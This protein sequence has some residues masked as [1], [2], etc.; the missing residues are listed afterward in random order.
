MPSPLTFSRAVAHTL[1][2]A[3]VACVLLQPSGAAAQP[4]ATHPRLWLTAADLPRLRAWA[5]DSNP[6]YR[7][8]LLRLATR[9]KASMDAGDVPGRDADNGGNTY[10]DEPAEMYAELF[11]FMSLVSPVEADRADYARRARTLLMYVVERALPGAAEGEPY[12]D[13]EFSVNDRSRWHGEAFALTADWI[14][15]SLSPSDRA[16]LRT[17]FLRWI[18]E[19]KNAAITAHDHPEPIGVVNDPRLVDDPAKLRWALNNY[20]TAHMRNIGLMS[21]ALDPA[22]DPDGSLRG[23]LGNATGAWLYVF[24][25]AA[26]TV[27]QGGL[28]PEG[29]E[30][31]PQTFGYAAQLLL[32]LK[33]AGQD[34]APANGP[35][36][37]VAGNPF[38]DEVVNGMLHSLSPAPATSAEG[39]SVHLPAWFGDGQH[40]LAPDMIALF[41]AL[42]VLDAAL[43]NT[44]R[45]DASRFLQRDLAPG[46]AP[47][48]ARR[49]YETE[50]Y[51][52]NAV[53]YFLLF[54]PTAPAPADPR[55]RL[56]LVHF[57][58]GL[59]RLL[60]RTAWDTSASWFTYKL[61]FNSVDHQ[62]GD[63]N[64]F[65]LY[66]KG[67]WLTK[68]RTGYDLEYGGA[69]NH[70]VVAIQNDRPSHDDPCAFRGINWVQGAQWA[71]VSTG[72]PTLRALG[73]GSDF[74][75]ALGDA[76][77]LYNSASEGSTDV[78]EATRS[79]VWLQPDHVVVYDRAATKT[80]GRFKRFWLNVTG[81]A[82]VSGNRTTAVTPGGQRLFVT[83][84]LPQD[85]QIAVEPA[86][87]ATGCGFEN[88][89]QATDD[90]IRSRLK[91][92]APGGPARTRFLNVLQG[93]DAGA[94]ADPVAL[95]ASSS[96]TP[97]AGALVAGNAVL[98]PVD[99]D[100]PFTSV[101]YS[102]PA[103]AG[104]VIHRVTGLAPT[105]R[106][107]V[108]A[109]NVGGGH[110]VTITA[111][112][113]GQAPDAAGVL[114]FPESATPPSEA[115]TLLVPIVLSSAGLGAFF[116]T[117]LTLTNR[118]TTPATLSF[119]YTAALG[120]T[121]SGTATTT[122]AA[123]RQLIV[124]DAIEY[125][126]GLGVPLP[127]SGNRAGT[128][129]ATFTGISS[130]TAGAVTART[131]S[132]VPQG[133]AGLAYA[134]VPSASTLTGPAWLYGLRQN[135]VDRS[136]VA[137]LHAG[138]PSDGDVTLR[139][140]VRPSDG[141]ALRPVAEMVLAP[142][143]FQQISQVLASNGLSLAAGAVRVERV[144]G[145]APY[146]AY[147]VVNDQ[148]NG[149]GSFVPPVP[150]EPSASPASLTL[151]V[152]VEAGS[153]SSELV[154]ADGA[155]RARTL[156]LRFVA[157]GVSTADH[158]ARF[159]LSLAA[160]EQR[161]IPGIVQSLRSQGVAGIGAPGGLSGALFVT[162]RT[163]NSGGLFVGARTS[164]PGGGGA[165]G[166][167]YPATPGG[168]ASDGPVWLYGIQQNAET[169]TNLAL[170]NT[171]EAGAGT[172][173]FR[174]EIF[175][176]ATGAL[177]RTVEG[178]AVEASGWAQIGTLLATYAP[179][180]SNGYARIT[181]V[182]GANPFLAYTVVNDGG[183]PGE[184]TG[185]GAFVASQPD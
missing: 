152:L 140:T 40:Y 122:L 65:E 98:F 170:V 67:E 166:V 72:D 32:A 109:R 29:F 38:W 34:G 17:V 11:A 3:A 163:G 119:A 146:Y 171:G 161:S 9:A 35:Q 182:S 167:F 160:N 18:E 145:T 179:G 108:S 53:L 99:L 13:P 168:R 149:D 157:S 111:S 31:F 131:T 64:Q 87:A 44:A 178:L 68:E 5:T 158:T 70:N 139:L 43:G 51:Y 148:A 7:D 61:S 25:R 175:D 49:A 181:R 45:R 183:A 30:Y 126:R 153:F 162:D 143:S 135:A 151:P 69:Q 113:S 159:S 1:A 10:V 66:R 47:E 104:S 50:G 123:G 95:L 173:V 150:E 75:Y 37:T 118:G 60:A 132:L 180:V 19:N 58:P 110:E 177:V 84:L 24:D 130:R 4:V 129:R 21:M 48:L 79:I 8:G 52:Q 114:R 174:I 76:T 127:A 55:P 63:G 54:D 22:D 73:T 6:V 124:P 128:L 33:T 184:R 88:G 92:E 115:A 100:V 103:P 176:G 78:V 81:P 138:G 120:G 77:N 136:N 74:A 93:A 2:A 57:A 137:V 85:A 185:D 46:G 59:G 156:D 121:G 80:A 27:G 155:G 91:V 154:L 20:F 97:Y 141:S 105:G 36:S 82:E 23:A 89:F 107:T 28:G 172:D 125:L 102:V 96:G 169:R 147:G 106:Y 90:P 41:G 134:G 165:Y 39:R 12:R 62:Y 16:A 144:A 15:P 112:G 164:A 71:Y 14:Y 116:T 94:S 56:P 117:E 142:G 26:R 101:T 86:V 133:R 83:T 42:G